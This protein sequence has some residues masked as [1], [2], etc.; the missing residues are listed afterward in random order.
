MRGE[1][2]AGNGEIAK[3]RAI[4]VHCCRVFREV[5]SFRDASGLDF[6]A[7]WEELAA[8]EKQS[9]AADLDWVRQE[10]FPQEREQRELR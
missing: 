5:K 2:S 3:I 6:F 10:R 4:H 8:D 9:S 1:G 7:G